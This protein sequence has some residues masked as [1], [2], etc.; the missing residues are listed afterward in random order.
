M[1]YLNSHGVEELEAIIISHMHSD[2][3]GSLTRVIEHYQTNTVYYA[4]V[5][6]GVEEMTLLHRRL[7]DMIEKRGVTLCEASN[8]EIFSLGRAQVEIYPL[9]VQ[10]DDGNDYSLFARVS[11]G[12][13]AI[14][15]TGDATEKGQR[16]LIRSGLDIEASVIKLSHHGAKIDSTRELL[17]AVKPKRALLSC[18]A[19]NIYGHPH[20]DTMLALKERGILCH[21]TDANGYIVMTITEEGEYFIETS[22]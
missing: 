3:I 4:A 16:A 12:S 14:L 15:F 10:S 1:S 21:R 8:G 11:Y 13:E 9:S 17:D 20:D 2:H 5:P 19:E 22:R 7:Y 18:L 6:E